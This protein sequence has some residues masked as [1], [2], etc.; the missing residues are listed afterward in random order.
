M[1]ANSQALSSLALGDFTLT[2]QKK[3]AFYFIL[4]KK[5]IFS[6]WDINLSSQ[7]QPGVRH[8]KGGYSLLPVINKPFY[9]AIALLSAG[10][11]LPLRELRGEREASMWH[12]D[13]GSLA[14]LS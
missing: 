4:Q 8:V 11:V 5:L 13:A 2:Q 1:V 7:K 6:C 9:R 14:V 12:G 10:H 3:R